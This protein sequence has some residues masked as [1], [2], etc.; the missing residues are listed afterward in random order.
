MNVAM[1]L[2]GGSG[3]RTQ[4]D[5]PKQ[6]INVND[7]PIVI[8]TLESFQK[9]PDVDAILVVCLEGWFEILWA[10][11]R[12]YG[13]A[14]LRWV[15]GGGNTV[16]ESIRNG[17][18]FLKDKCSSDDIVIIHDGI[19]PLVEE[20]VIS[21]VIVK[22]RKYG[23]AVTALPYYEQIFVV[24]DDI[25]TKQYVPREILRRVQTPQAYR[26]RKLLWAYEEAFSRGIGISGSSYTNTLMV[27]LGETLYFAVG[28]GK[29]IK[30]TTLDDIEIFRGLIRLEEHR[31][32]SS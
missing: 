26:Y 16:Q 27:D 25:S 28:S 15:V 24:Q 9:H 22:C 11:A 18:V 5:I 20:T 12:Q 17:V 31:D 10:Y 19:R 32:K 4:Q 8:Y 6:F 13:I 21:D 7:K 2:A 23:N 14:K 29:N 3:R 1:I 30:I